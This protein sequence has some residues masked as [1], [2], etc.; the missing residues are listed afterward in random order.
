MPGR[1]AV[2]TVSPGMGR[3][4]TVVG[5]GTGVSPARDA[6]RAVGEG[7]RGGR[8]EWGRGCGAPRPALLAAP[9][10]WAVPRRRRTGAG[11]AGPSA[12]FNPSGG[13]GGG[14]GG[15]GGAAPRQPLLLSSNRA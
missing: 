13:E 10:G 2:A 4:H 3:V 15:R 8:G 9:I 1:L 12:P 14:G 6:A 7:P 11:G 5:T